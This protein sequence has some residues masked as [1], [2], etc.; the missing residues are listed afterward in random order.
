VV[1]ILVGFV[2]VS[3]TTTAGRERER[4]ST[5]ESVCA[6]ELAVFLLCFPNLF[7]QFR[8]LLCEG[9]H[10]HFSTTNRLSSSPSYLRFASHT[11]SAFHLNFKLAA[12]CGLYRLVALWP[13][14]L[15]VRPRPS[16]E[17]RRL[18]LYWLLLLSCPLWERRRS[19]VSMCACTCMCVWMCM[20]I[21]WNLCLCV[22]FLFLSFFA[23]LFV[24]FSL[25][26]SFIFSFRLSFSSFLPRFG[27]L[28][29]SFLFLNS[30]VTS[31][32][33]L[34]CA[35]ATALFKLTSVPHSPAFLCPP[36]LAVTLW[37]P[38]LAITV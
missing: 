28:P 17:M 18:L 5:R 2:W 25:L 4:G 37:P 23:S 30:Q 22:S 21:C 6:L 9:W 32:F 19:P 26:L 3:G 7:V 15:P 11:L 36:A 38:S 29:P 24:S 34:F 8:R 31:F 12:F 20:C 13:R 14:S 16:D 10:G 33:L 27:S 1:A 35:S